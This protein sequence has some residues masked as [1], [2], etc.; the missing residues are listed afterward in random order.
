MREYVIISKSPKCQLTNGEINIKLVEK[1]KYL[2]II[3]TED[4]KCDIDNRTR[5]VLA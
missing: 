4:G 2:G 5:S 1:I 3:L